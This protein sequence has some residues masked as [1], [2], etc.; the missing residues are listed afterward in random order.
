MKNLL[1]IY[2]I[3]LPAESYRISHGYHDHPDPR[4]PLSLV[5]SPVARK[6]ARP[7]P[8][9][10]PAAALGHAGS[11]APSRNSLAV[12]GGTHQRRSA[13]PPYRP[14]MRVA[15]PSSPQFQSFSPAVSLRFL[16]H[17]PRWLSTLSHH[18]DLRHRLSGRGMAVAAA[19]SVAEEPV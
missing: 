5:P 18:S 10:S 16:L 12:P 6:L 7:P 17:R 4:Q 13:G 2:E 19:A 1:K 11:R 14:S 9:R 8:A 15:R 3:S